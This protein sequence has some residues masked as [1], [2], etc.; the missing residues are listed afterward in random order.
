MTGISGCLSQLF[1]AYDV[2]C[3]MGD[4]INPYLINNTDSSKTTY[5]Y[6]SEPQ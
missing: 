1:A 3:L 4:S 2:H 5:I 6:T